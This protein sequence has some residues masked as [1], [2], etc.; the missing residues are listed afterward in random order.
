M[1]T[2]IDAT[3]YKR[4]GPD[5][6][7]FTV[8][9]ASGQEMSRIQ[10]SAICQTMTGRHRAGLYFLWPVMAQ[11]GAIDESGMVDQGAYFEAVKAFEA[12]GVCTRFPH[13]S[14]LYRTLL[15]KEWQPTLC[16]VPSLHIPPAVMVNRASVMASPQRAARLVCSAL[17][18]I[19]SAK[20][21]KKKPEPEALRLAESEARRGVAKMGFA[22]EAAHVRVFRGEEQMATAL[23]ELA[24][25]AGVTSAQVIVQV[26]RK[27]S[28]TLAAVGRTQSQSVSM[29]CHCRRFYRPRADLMSSW[30]PTC[31]HSL[32]ALLIPSLR[33][34]VRT[35]R[36][37]TL[38]FGSS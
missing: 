11:D 6:E 13:P 20:Y 18:E 1:Q 7:V 37:T 2:F 16:L 23:Y 5:Y 35:L 24:A 21:N 29:L 9:V 33:S 17:A 28:R 26:R 22:W 25:Q 15:S 36:R 30:R 10:P 32:T 12:V 8:F 14:Q 27:T 34:D 38:S 4:L 19:R 31:A 3:V